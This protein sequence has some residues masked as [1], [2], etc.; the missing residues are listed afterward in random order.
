MRPR[1]NDRCHGIAVSFEL[2]DLH[3]ISAERHYEAAALC[4]QA[5]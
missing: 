1:C 3:G 5:E 2:F 4:V